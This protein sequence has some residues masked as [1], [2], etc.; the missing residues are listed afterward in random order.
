MLPQ[1]GKQASGKVPRR[2]AAHRLRRSANTTADRNTPTYRE[3]VKQAADARVRDSGPD[4]KEARRGSWWDFASGSRGGLSQKRARMG[5]GT[6]GVQAGHQEWRQRVLTCAARELAAAMKHG[7]RSARPPASRGGGCLAR[8]QPSHQTHR[9]RRSRSAPARDLG[10]QPVPSKGVAREGARKTLKC[11]EETRGSESP[12]K[13]KGLGLVR[14]VAAKALAAHDPEFQHAAR[15]N[16]N[17]MPS[18]AEAGG[19]GKDLLAF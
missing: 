14:A 13:A 3:D 4:L 15:A 19:A 10:A 12:F 16:M 2:L 1:E 9:K 18:S 8:A 7:A 17:A 11:A 5:M 6:A